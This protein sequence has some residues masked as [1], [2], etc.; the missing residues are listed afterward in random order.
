MQDFLDNSL[1]VS[2]LVLFVKYNKR[3]NLVMVVSVV[4]SVVRLGVG[5]EGRGGQGEALR[6][7]HGST[8]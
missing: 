5:G 8:P 7:L 4:M 2:F 3:T 1:Q 6:V